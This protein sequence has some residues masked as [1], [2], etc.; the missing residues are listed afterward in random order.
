MAASRKAMQSAIASGVLSPLVMA[1]TTS[2]RAMP[3]ETAVTATAVDKA[4]AAVVI[5]STR[6]MG[7]CLGAGPG[8]APGLIPVGLVNGLG[9]SISANQSTHLSRRMPAWIRPEL[10][11]GFGEEGQICVFG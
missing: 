11:E 8:R 3:I 5:N 10:G 2:A 1:P 9:M 4:S 7:R 6:V